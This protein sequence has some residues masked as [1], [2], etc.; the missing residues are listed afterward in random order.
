MNETIRLATVE[1]AEAM[2]DIYRPYVEH[3]AV[4]FELD[5]P[6]AAEFAKRVAHTLERYPWLV[7]DRDGVVVGYAYA[8]PLKSRAAYNHSVEV[9]IYL[10]EDARGQGL[11][12]R[13]YDNLEALLRGLGITNLYACVTYSDGEHDPYLTRDSVFFH[14]RVGYMRVGFSIIAVGNLI[15]STQSYGWKRFWATSSFPPDTHQVSVWWKSLVDNTD[16]MRLALD[17]LLY[18]S[19][20][21]LRGYRTNVGGRRRPNGENQKRKTLEYRWRSV[22]I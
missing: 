18:G 22:V 7:L 5:P 2:L 4:S 10:R 3:T 21:L 16:R 8:G 1:D 17:V 15:G 14:E 6:D 20:R 12:R 11:G 19:S 13:L 9:S